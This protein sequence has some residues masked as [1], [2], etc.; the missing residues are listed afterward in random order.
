M[1]GSRVPVEEFDKNAARKLRRPSSS[2]RR[3]GSMEATKKDNEYNPPVFV[4]TE[5]EFG[6]RSSRRKMLNDEREARKKR[7]AQT[8]T[9][10]APTPPPP[11]R[12]QPEPRR[13][14]MGNF[15]RALDIGQP[16][17]FNDRR[18]QAQIVLPS[19]DEQKKAAQKKFEEE[20]MAGCSTSFAI[21]MDQMI[22]FDTE[23]DRASRRME[24]QPSPYWSPPEPSH[25]ETPNPPG[26]PQETIQ[27]SPESSQWSA[28]NPP[29]SSE[30]APQSPPEPSH[31]NPP[32]PLISNSPE[33]LEMQNQ[34]SGCRKLDFFLR[35]LNDAE[36]RDF[37]NSHLEQDLLDRLYM[38]VTR[39]Y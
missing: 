5:E 34:S 28:E 36:L 24:L 30:E 6:F 17:V 33:V 11:V 39:I 25:Q 4:N 10:V 15:E 35:L 13:T 14:Y 38:A 18:E 12:E 27:N 26:S 16:L 22:Q 32:H 21:P 7:E 20:Q 29:E 3:T 37:I 23:G 8:R 9:S 1:Y 31:G 2:A 19:V